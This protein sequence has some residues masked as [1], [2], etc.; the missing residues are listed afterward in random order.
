MTPAPVRGDGFPTRVES[1]T[2]WVEVFRRA[3]GAGDFASVA[4]LA[5]LTHPDYRAVQPQAPDALGPAG[6]L[7]FFARVYALV[8]D[9]RG[10]VVDAHV[11][12]GGVH[13]EVRLSGTVG[14]RPVGWV[15][16]DRFWFEDGFVK[17]RTTYFDPIPLFAA[18]ATRPRAWRRWWR[19][20]LGLPT[21]RI[22]G[23]LDPR[24][25]TA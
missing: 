11:H 10:E 2:H 20:G 24:G 18:V 22:A 12:D 19:S 14:G 4:R 23:R 1:P 7:D 21:R 16:C 6:M 25:R 17:G 13:I 5:E 8:P 3:F 15:A 9:L